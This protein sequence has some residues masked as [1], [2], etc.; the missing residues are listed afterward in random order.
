MQRY[1]RSL[2]L[3]KSS[4]LL[5]EPMHKI[6]VLI[7]AMM[8]LSV[9]SVSFAAEASPTC[10]A[11]HAMY[12]VGSKTFS[13]APAAANKVA[14]SWTG[15]AGNTSTTYSFNNNLEFK[16][17]FSDTNFLVAGYPE[18][19]SFTGVTTSAI[20]MRHSSQYLNINHKLTATINKPVSKYGF[21]VQD[22]DSN[23]NGKYTE[24]ISIF[25]AGGAFSN[26][27]TANYTLS[28]ASKTITGNQWLNC[29]PTSPCNFNID[30]GSQSLNTPFVITHGNA[31]SSASTTLSTGDHVVG[32]S[33]FYFC[34][35][36]PKL[37][38]KKQL[39]GT[40]FNDSDTKRDQFNIKVAGGK[41]TPDTQ[42]S[43]ASFTTTGTGSTITNGSTVTPLELAP[44]TTYTISENIISGNASNYST[45]YAC[46]NATTGSTTTMP[47]GTASSFTLS[48]LNYGDEVT[49]TITNTPK[50]YSFSGT[51]FN[52][53]GGITAAD[54]T[55]QNIT[56]T[57]TGNSAYFNGILDSN[58]SGIFDSGLQVALTNCNGTQIVTSSA[59]PQ[60]VSSLGK[61]NFVVQSGALPTRVCLVETEP[62]SW[63]YDIDTTA[64]IREVT[65]TNDIY[66]YNNLD[67][68]EVQANN[69]ALVLIK[70]QYVHECN[71]SLDYTSV[72]NTSDPSTGFSTSAPNNTI[73]PGKC[74]AYKIEAYNRGHISLS[75]IQIS[76]VLQNV[77]VK[78][79]FYLPKALGV[80][81]DVFK[82]T[83][84]TAPIGQNGT[85]VS[86]KFT[87]SNTSSS[88]T[89]SKATL[90]FNTKYGTTSGT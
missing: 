87:L 14:L 50:S 21:V 82:T 88:T 57:F 35:A 48:S 39:E 59:N 23:E 20:N 36:P 13:P 67:F 30:W 16:L 85:I 46:T 24:S 33:D 38:V 22:L 81:S 70:Y 52:D 90:Y 4:S 75:D 9:S 43:T 17:S 40:R 80:P 8:L 42:G 68:G 26:I 41:L 62:T 5:D 83:N 55:K 19:S 12:Y 28:N 54:S 58:E 25:S 76:D 66:V 45:S 73:I 3:A 61:Y 47:S 78:S 56:S 31:Y 89:A 7:V 74:I 84:Q 11:D 79:E 44:S 65:L 29:N 49:C 15:G 51:V 64:N 1:Q 37:T 53:N 32:Y 72:T 69:T 71:S 63:I 6:P 18:A 34:L 2:K 77:K 86:D 60:T 27:L 10:P